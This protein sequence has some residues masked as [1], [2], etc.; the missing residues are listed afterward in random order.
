MKGLLIILACSV[1]I[2][3]CSNA[4]EPKKSNNYSEAELDKQIIQSRI[5][6]TAESIQSSIFV[7]K[8]A[9]ETADQTSEINDKLFVYALGE[10]ESLFNSYSIGGLD[11]AQD[12]KSNR[13]I[14]SEA[15]DSMCIINK[16]LDKYSKK[17]SNDKYREMYADTL[18]QTL[19]LQ[20][21][22]I[23][24]LTTNADPINDSQCLTL[25]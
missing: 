8:A 1:F 16:F 24:I 5:M 4:K 2:S 10:I 22:Y 3:A 19:K 25:K 14:S 15:I 20:S 12:L 9:Y 21:H 6:A 11:Y 17:L 23:N 7:Y 18:F 13:L